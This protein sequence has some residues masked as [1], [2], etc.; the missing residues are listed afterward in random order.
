MFENWESFFITSTFPTNALVNLRERIERRSS[1]P[2]MFQLGNL[3]VISQ[4][5]IEKIE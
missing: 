5:Q 1:N 2:Q 3:Q 4:I